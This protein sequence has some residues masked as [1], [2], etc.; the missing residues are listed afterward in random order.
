MPT[1][2]PVIALT[3]VLL[4]LLFGLGLYYAGHKPFSPTE[5]MRVLPIV[6]RFGCALVLVALISGLGRRLFPLSTLSPL[7]RLALQTALGGGFMALATLIIGAT[8]GLSRWFLQLSGVVL[9][10]VLRQEIWA[11]LKEWR[12]LKLSWVSATWA[13]RAVAVSSGALIFMALL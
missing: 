7:E 5:V 4:W 2:R 9:L 1:R 13:G 8:L 12:A 11:W 3:L 10:I 6:G